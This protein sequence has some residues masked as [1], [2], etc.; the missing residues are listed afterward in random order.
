ML[1]LLK[2]TLISETEDIWENDFIP[3]IKHDQ[4]ISV[5]TWSSN[6]AHLLTY[7]LENTSKLWDFRTRTL[8]HFLHH[9]QHIS[10]CRFSAAAKAF[11]FMDF[12]GYVKIWEDQEGA[13]VSKPK[14]VARKPT[15][16]MEDSDVDEEAPARKLNWKEDAIEENK[17]DDESLV[18]EE[19]AAAA[20]LE[21]ELEVE[22]EKSKAGDD[23]D[24]EPEMKP[25]EKDQQMEQE[26]QTAVGGKD[27][28]ERGMGQLT[29]SDVAID[30]TA[31]ELRE[32]PIKEKKVK[33][34][35]DRIINYYPQEVLYPS[36]TVLSKSRR[37]LCWNLVGSVVFREE[38]EFSWIDVEFTNKAFHKNLYLNN[39][40]NFTIA[41]LNE[42]GVVLASRVEEEGE[43]DYEDEFKTEERKYSH[44]RFK[45]FHPI[46]EAPKEWNYRLPEGEVICPLKETLPTFYPIR[47]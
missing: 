29:L 5:V 47:T 25:E 35:A 4:E 12:D 15:V 38:G 37:F 24:M 44:V 21:E 41:T 31:K 28:V 9:T 34:Q 10:S 1:Q 6:G 14:V 26:K 33:S 45:P 7:G 27:S 18:E 23:D 17:S 46:F 43:D 19:L 40:Y 32:A 3:E 39:D 20:E 2:R 36:S 42:R 13:I 22:K 8:L 16:R 11:A 30:A